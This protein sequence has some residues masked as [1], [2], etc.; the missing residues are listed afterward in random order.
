[1]G[2]LVDAVVRSAASSGHNVC[3]APFLLPELKL[4]VRSPL[5]DGRRGWAVPMDPQ[6]ASST[7]GTSG[8][9]GPK[10]VLRV[11]AGAGWA[12]VATSPCG[13]G[14]YSWDDFVATLNA[15]GTRLRGRK[16]RAEVLS[17]FPGPK[18]LR[19][20]FQYFEAHTYFG[21]DAQTRIATANALVPGGFTAFSEWARKNMSRAAERADDRGLN[22]DDPTTRQV[23]TL[24]KL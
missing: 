11:R 17:P 19:E 24:A 3:Q 7:P 22:R 10:A 12:T 15:L 4:F 18:E 8:E 21:P 14:T 5:P 9:L 6:R 13:G 23:P 16:G 1:M 2:A 20:M